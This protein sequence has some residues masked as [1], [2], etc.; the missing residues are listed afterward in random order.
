MSK[1][2]GKPRR[3]LLPLLFC[4]AAALLLGSG[5]GIVSR[6]TNDS[7][8]AA[9]V[10]NDDTI[11]G[12]P[13]DIPEPFIYRET[14]P[15]A[16]ETSS[17]EPE[18]A[19]PEPTA[20]PEDSP[21]PEDSPTPEID[22]S[23]DT[24]GRTVSGGNGSSTKKTTKTN[25]PGATIPGITPSRIVIDSISCDAPILPVGRTK[26]GRMGTVSYAQKVAWYQYGATPGYSGNALVAGHVSWN[27]VKGSF[28]YLTYLKIGAK[29]TVTLSDGSTVLFE[30]I[31][32]EQFPESAVP[33]KHLE[34]DGETRMTLITCSG[35]YD[36]SIGT[37]TKRCVVVLR[38]ITMTKKNGTVFKYTSS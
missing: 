17:P 8:L 32:N 2:N 24:S 21:E 22:D 4:V 16:P 34:L 18:I 7:S 6:V 3:W 12:L 19:T 30:V 36:S 27:R 33:D 1:P 37:H 28:Y 9:N 15:P 25:S 31:S 29:C 26:D 5:V 10:A 14:D 38:P 23:T 11:I 13:I 20:T 35:V